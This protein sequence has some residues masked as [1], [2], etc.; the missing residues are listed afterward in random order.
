MA[1]SVNRPTVFKVTVLPP[2]LGPVMMRVSKSSPS[3]RVTGTTFSLS[4]RGWRAFTS[5]NRPSSL[6]L[7]RMPPCSRARTALAKMQSRRPR[8]RRLSYSSSA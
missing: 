6:S 1:M 8:S 5:F 3:H 4:I 7:G 2:V